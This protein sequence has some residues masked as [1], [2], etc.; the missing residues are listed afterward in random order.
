MSKHQRH[1]KVRDY[2]L[3]AGLAEVF[4]PGRHYPTYLAEKVIFHSKLRGA[5]LGRLQKLAFHRFYSE[6]IFDLR[7]EIT[8]V[9]DQA[10]LTAYFQFFD[11]LFFFGSLGG[12]KRCILKCDSKLT[13][14]GGP[15]GKFS[16][17]EVLNVQQGKQGQIYEIKIYRQRGENR[18]YSLRTALGFMLQAMCHAFLRLWQCWSGHCSEMWGEHGAGWAWQDMAL[19]IEKAVADGHFV[20]LDIPLGRLEMLADNLRAYPAYLKDEQLRRWR[21]DPKKLARLAGRN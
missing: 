21:I 7:P 11:E 15:R 17:R 1:R 13:D 16:R 14:I 3:H 6:K 9:P 18:Y 19:A 20:N 4:T 10:V 5:E 8:D 2:N 12:S